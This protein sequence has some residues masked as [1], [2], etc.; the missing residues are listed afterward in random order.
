MKREWVG[1]VLGAWI[2]ISPWVFGTA[3][4]GFMKWSNVLVGLA[5]VI[6]NAWK[7]FSKETN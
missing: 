5:L 3:A 6:M 2:L 4:I 1:L 7:I